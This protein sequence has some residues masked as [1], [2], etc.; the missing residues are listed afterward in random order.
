MKEAI[1]YFD[2][3]IRNGKMALGYI[4]LDPKDQTILFQGYRK[5]GRGSSN[6]AEYRGLMAGL[7]HAIK[8]KI[9]I[10]RII[11]DSQLIIKQVTGAFQVKNK[12]LKKHNE[13]VLEYLTEFDEWSIKWVPRKQN[14]LADYLVNLAFEGNKNDKKK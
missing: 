2:G 5:C 3:G 1:L 10:I 12:E 7:L 14:T 8:E 9:K 6:I 13:K 11:G 4:A